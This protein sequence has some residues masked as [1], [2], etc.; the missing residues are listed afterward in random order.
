M[1]QMIEEKGD[2]RTCVIIGAAM[3]VHREPGTPAAHSDPCHLR[4]LRIIFLEVGRL[5]QFRNI[6]DS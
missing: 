1:K 3:E 6:A 2:E 4:N 5:Q